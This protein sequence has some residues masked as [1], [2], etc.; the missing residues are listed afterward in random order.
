MPDPIRRRTSLLDLAIIASTAVLPILLV[1][2][3]MVASARQADMLAPQRAGDRHVSV[4]L[5]AALKTFE[6]AVTRRDRITSA[7]PTPQILRERI[8][9]CR[10]AWEGIG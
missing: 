6:H 10:E 5:V 2:L 1:V 3:L 9:Q 8:P 7:L 4:R